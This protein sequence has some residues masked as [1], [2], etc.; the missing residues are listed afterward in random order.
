[1]R[2][3]LS[4]LLLGLS[5]GLAPMSAVADRVHVAA[6]SSLQ[7]AMPSLIERF[8]TSDSDASKDGDIDLSVTFGASGNLQRQIEQG[9]PFALFLSADERRARDLEQAGLTQ[10]EGVDY[11]QGRLVWL[12]RDDRPLPPQDAPLE[13][14]RE[15]VVGLEQGGPVRRIALANP[16]HAPYGMAARE[17]LERQGLWQASEPLQLLGENVAQAA[18]FALSA[19]ASGGLVAY[20]LVKAPRLAER[21]GWRLIPADWHRPLVQR[22]VLLEGAGAGAEAFFDFLQTPEAQEILRDYGFT[23][24]VTGE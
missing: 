5:L 14:V 19:E 10:G 8:K 21:A 11:A 3:P 12:Q 16:R 15:A 4:I 9:A 20:S 13:A 17:V 1:M 6:A 18:Q 2:F 7:F 24:P 23:A 22:M